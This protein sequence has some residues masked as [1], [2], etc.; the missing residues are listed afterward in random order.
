MM[1]SKILDDLT[2]L[3]KALHRQPEVAGE[4]SATSEK[5]IEYLGKFSPD[6]IEKGIGGYGLIAEFRGESPGPAVMFRCELDGLP[7]PEKSDLP[8]RS[9]YSGRG[10]LCGHDGHMAMVSGLAHYLKKERPEKGRV[11]LL[12]QPSEEDGR[13]AERML[14]DPKFKDFEPDYIFAIHNLPGFPLHEVI[15]S[16]GHFAAASRGMVIQ[17]TGKSSHAAEPEKGNNPALAMSS[18][19]T[20]FNDV[21]QIKDHFSDF[22]LITP[23]HAR[24]GSIAYGTSPGEGVIHLTL[25]SYRDDDMARMTD[26]LEKIVEETASREALQYDIHYEEVFPATLNNSEC[27]R[28]ISQVCQRSGIEPDYLEKPFKWSEDFGHFTAKYK[29]ALFG[30]GS[31]KDQSALHNPDFDF[32]DRLIPTGVNIF[33]EIY[34][35]ILNR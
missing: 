35:E 7:I 9:I 28:V 26:M 25:R 16:N 5:I 22:I 13:G 18:L 4:E 2:G 8:Y 27:S 15:L 17:L 14:K 12:F 20:A 19:I 6:R 24:L 29:G 21:L 31:G 3:R 34:L 10:H 33:R 23:I 32:P 1:D 30:L 11:L